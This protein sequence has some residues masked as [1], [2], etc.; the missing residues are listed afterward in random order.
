MHRKVVNSSVIRAIGYDRATNVLEVEFHS[1]RI[2]QYFMVPANV[3]ET[4]LLA[5]SIGNF[6]NREIR[7]EFSCVAVTNE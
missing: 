6:F 3:H 5:D 4:L 1:G 7:N 2:Y